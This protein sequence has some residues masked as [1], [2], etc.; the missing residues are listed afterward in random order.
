MKP[1]FV[2][3]AV[4]GALGCMVTAQSPPTLQVQPADALVD[5]PTTIVASGLP[6]RQAVSVTARAIDSRGQVFVGQARFSADAH[7]VVD[8]SAANASGS[9]AGVDAM[10]LFWSMEP[11]NP[12]RASQGEAR[13]ALGAAPV[14]YEFNVLVEGRSVAKAEAV[15]R[16]AAAS[17]RTVAVRDR[18]L[19][20]SV[21]MPPGE[22]RHPAILHFGGSE[23]GF[24]RDPA[25]VDLLASRGYVVLSLA[26]FNAPSLPPTLSNIPIEYFRTALDW[27][28]EQ[29]YVDGNRVGVMSASR[30]S[31]AALLLA[32]LFEDVRAVVV[33]APQSVM[34]AGWD[35]AT[36]RGTGT[37][38]W[39]FQGR[40]LAYVSVLPGPCGRVRGT[41]ADVLRCALT[42]Y[43]EA[44]SH[45]TIPVDKTKAPLFLV[46][47]LDDRVSPSDAMAKQIEDRRARAHVGDNDVTLYI[48]H[49]GH[50]IPTWY[51]PPSLDFDHIGGNR[52]GAAKAFQQAW[53]ALVHFLHVNLGGDEG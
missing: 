31:E 46:V 3:T 16:R 24:P 13:F 9:Y 26:Y 21:T 12:P 40:S 39:S 28:K 43:R 32:I 38:A 27:L 42:E 52:E 6:P 8:L 15:R 35:P 7:G 10:G 30:G 41:G 51:G 18:S 34:W 49:A 45:A 11:E 50:Q 36:G 22:G 2:I 44:V 19:V 48:K 14:R 29:P 37:P 1:I 25:R 53:P 17:V 23:G 4:C 33:I 20:G 47:G 5:A